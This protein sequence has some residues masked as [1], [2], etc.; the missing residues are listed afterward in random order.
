MGS[1]LLGCGNH[2]DCK[3]YE[4]ILHLTKKM[5]LATKSTIW[6]QLQILLLALAN[7]ALQQTSS[8]SG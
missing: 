5:L 4:K 3:Q 6:L 2:F 1:K 8:C 7:Y